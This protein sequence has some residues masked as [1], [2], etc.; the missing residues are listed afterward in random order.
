M[1]MGGGGVPLRVIF[2]VISPA[3]ASCNEPARTTTDSD[4]ANFF[5]RVIACTSIGLTTD[6]R[7]KISME[8]GERKPYVKLFTKA[9]LAR[10]E[11][12]RSNNSNWE[13]HDPHVQ[14]P[15]S[16][17]EDFL[18]FAKKHL[19]CRR[20]L[21]DIHGIAKKRVLVRS[22]LGRPKTLHWIRINGQRAKFLNQVLFGLQE[23][24]GFNAAA[25][26]IP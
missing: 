7:E 24:L 20:V 4:K 23:L 3:E 9:N 2:P 14:L 5:I 26:V 19:H 6:S 1:V 15:K 8:R 21:L 16:C 11:K 12:E 10:K 22:S 25:V 13:R 18:E 17:L